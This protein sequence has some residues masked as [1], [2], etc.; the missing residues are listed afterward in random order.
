MEKKCYT[1]KL[2]KPLSEFGNNKKRPDGKQGYCKECGKQRDKKHYAANPDRKAS[3]TANREA[4]A[5][6]NRKYLIDYLK[7]HPCVDCGE[8][9]PLYPFFGAESPYSETAGR[10]SDR[11]KR[12]RLP[13]SPLG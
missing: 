13:T 4:A 5:R 9:E 2:P 7:G 12:G 1:C 3:I 10:Q 11:A 6:R 8:T